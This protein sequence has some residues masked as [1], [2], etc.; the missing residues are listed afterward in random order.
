MS[1][2]LDMEEHNSESK[3]KRQNVGEYEG[4][5]SDLITSGQLSNWSVSQFMEMSKIVH[6]ASK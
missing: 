2:A 3:A 5:E 1:A 6:E 4:K